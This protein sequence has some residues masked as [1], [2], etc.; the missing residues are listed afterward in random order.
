MIEG[1]GIKE[2]IEDREIILFLINKRFP[3][4]KIA[5]LLSTKTYRISYVLHKWEVDTKE[6]CKTKYSFLKKYDKPIV[7]VSSKEK[8]EKMNGHLRKKYIEN[9]QYKLAKLL[10]NRIKIAIKNGSK[11]G[12]AIRDLGCSIT[13]LKKWIESKF[14]AGMTWNNW[15]HKG[16]H[17]DHI[18]PLKSFDLT[19]LEQFKVAVHYTNLQPLWAKENQAKGAKYIS[20]SL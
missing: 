18:R 11:K 5:D 4:W 10:R 7:L 13:D 16:W 2:L 1:R 20:H 12:S 17:L 8:R 3:I 15:T 14:K 6:N 19:D 9:S